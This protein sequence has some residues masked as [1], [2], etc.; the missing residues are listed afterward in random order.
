MIDEVKHETRARPSVR[1]PI[2]SLPSLHRL[3]A[4][5][6]YNAHHCEPPDLMIKSR[7][8]AVLTSFHQNRFHSNGSP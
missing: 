4:V 6:A 7:K 1:A 2:P 5:F 3:V 8:P